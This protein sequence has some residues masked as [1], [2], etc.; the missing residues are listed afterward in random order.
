[1]QF[2]DKSDVRHQ[3]HGFLSISMVLRTFN[4][5]KLH[6]TVPFL[7]YTPNFIGECPRI[8]FVNTMNSY[9]IVFP[10]TRI[11]T[12]AGKHFD[13]MATLGHHRCGLLDV[14]SDASIC[15]VGRV[16]VANKGNVHFFKINQLLV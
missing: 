5:V 4:H 2:N 6:L 13:V 10:N 8:R 7:K 14:C 12:S 16:F 3:S 11:T 1:M 9:A 15:S